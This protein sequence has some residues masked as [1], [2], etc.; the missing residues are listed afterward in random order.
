MSGVVYGTGRHLKDIALPDIPR[1]L[2]FWWLCELFYTL[3]TAFI[4]LSISVFLLRIAVRPLYRNIIYGTM[5]VVVLYSTFY[6]FL[7]MFQ[8]TP[9][10]HFWLQ[11]AGQK[12]KCIDPAWVPDTSIAHSVINFTA[13]WVLGLLPIPLIWG[14]KMNTRTKVSVAGVLSLGLL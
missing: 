10:S 9:Y 3:A 4:R 5:A 8:C 1:A 11:Y 14:L 2:Y 12:G 6:F 7:I 13:D